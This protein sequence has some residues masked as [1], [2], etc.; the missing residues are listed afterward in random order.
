MGG[1]V[2][3]SFLLRFFVG[4]APL[5]GV[6]AAQGVQYLFADDQSRARRTATLWLAMVQALVLT[7]W[8]TMAGSELGRLHLMVTWLVV[9]AVAGTAISSTLRGRS[10]LRNGFIGVAFL[11]GAVYIIRSRPYPEP[12]P[13][14][15]IVAETADWFQTS[16]WRGRSV[17]TMRPYFWIR[18][19]IDPASMTSSFGYKAFARPLHDIVRSAAPGTIIVWDSH[20]FADVKLEE[21]NSSD[22]RLLHSV[23]TSEDPD[24]RFYRRGHAPFQM[25]VFEKVR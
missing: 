9:A 24:D 4:G 13:A 8:W 18:T 15:R 12:S 23:S 14:H 21:F 22:F 7:W 2:T 16:E 1:S 20:F 17:A 19:G 10:L 3:D 25:V 11:I 5:L 6:L